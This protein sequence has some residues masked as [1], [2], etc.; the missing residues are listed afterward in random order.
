MSSKT[1][2][3]L[4]IAIFMA[5]NPTKNGNKLFGKF[6]VTVRYLWQW[7]IEYKLVIALSLDPLE[8]WSKLCLS[9]LTTNIVYAH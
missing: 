4:A 7:L 3:R 5:I 8:A 6:L 2:D 1:Q 9:I